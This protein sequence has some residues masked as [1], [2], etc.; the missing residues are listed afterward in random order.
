MSPQADEL[1]NFDAHT[2]E[3]L[4]NTEEKYFVQLS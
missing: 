4:N 2:A 3:T 1:G